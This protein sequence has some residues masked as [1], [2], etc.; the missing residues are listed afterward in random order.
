MRFTFDDESAIEDRLVIEITDDGA[1]F[2]PEA[3]AHAC[4]RFYRDDASRTIA[5]DE[6]HYGIGLFVAAQ[7][8]RAHGGSLRLDNVR[9]AKGALLGALVALSLPLDA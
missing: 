8:T 1:G 7:A 2:S 6:P 4:E 5:A 3:L 9:D